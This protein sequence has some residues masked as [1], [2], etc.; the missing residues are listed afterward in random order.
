LKTAHRSHWLLVCIRR[1]SA[2]VEDLALIE[3]ANGA[4]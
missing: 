2:R 3:D 4:K 1:H